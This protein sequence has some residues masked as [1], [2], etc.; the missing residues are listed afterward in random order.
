MAKAANNK[1]WFFYVLGGD[2]PLYIMT[3]C[4]TYYWWGGY[5]GKGGNR[6]FRMDYPGCQR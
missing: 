3:L 5:W 6:E 2:N 4:Q 1:P